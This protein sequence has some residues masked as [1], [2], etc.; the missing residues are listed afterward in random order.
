MIKNQILEIKKQREIFSNSL[1]LI[2]YLK[3][4]IHQTNTNYKNSYKIFL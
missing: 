1:D 2:N 3:N 4:K